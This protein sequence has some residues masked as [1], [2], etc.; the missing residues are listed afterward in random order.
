[1]SAQSV[2]K[3]RALRGTGTLHYRFTEHGYLLDEWK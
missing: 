1:M 2:A 3:I